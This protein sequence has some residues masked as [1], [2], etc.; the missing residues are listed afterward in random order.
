MA[1]NYYSEIH[2]HMVWHTKES[3]PLLVPEV[4]AFTHSYIR[5]KLVNTPG[6]FI[7]EI[8][9]TETHVHLAVTVA[10]TI[11]ISDLVGKLKGA[12][13]HETNQ[14]FGQNSKPL[15]WQAGYG[16]VSFGTAHLPWVISYIRNQRLHHSRGTVEE[17]LERVIPD[18]PV[19]EAEQREGP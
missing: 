4:E 17:R 9:G 5:G 14:R 1:R 16:V 12:S 15:I 10:P 8:G 2:L 19:A 3:S 11:L 13:S 18:E 6:A 7:R